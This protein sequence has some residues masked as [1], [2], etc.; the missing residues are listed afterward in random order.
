MTWSAESTIATATL[1][2][3]NCGEFFGC[4]P[5]THERVSEIPVIAIDNSS[6]AFAGTLYAAFT[7]GLGLHAGRGR[8]LQEWRATRSTPVR[9]TPA[10]DKHDQFFNWIHVSSKGV[11][12]ITWLDR[13]NDPAN[14]N[15][16][17][18]AAFSTN[19][20]S[21]FKQIKISQAL[22][23]IR[24]M[25]VSV[26]TSWVTTRASWYGTKLY[27]AACDTRN[28]TSCQDELYGYFNAP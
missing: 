18:F 26:V 7:T 13:R 20:A 4:L 19:G 17:A 15:Y 21:V 9:V 8:S 28:G 27:V 6:G 14:I 24:S 1:A 10:T 2:K 3:D 22:R 23:P 25:T 16:Q 11:V 12:G 5:N